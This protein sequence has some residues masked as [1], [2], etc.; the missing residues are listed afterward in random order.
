[1]GTLGTDG[2]RTPEVTALLEFIRTTKRGVVVR[3][4]EGNGE[5]EEA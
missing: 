3:P 5:D 1:V 2:P 4:R